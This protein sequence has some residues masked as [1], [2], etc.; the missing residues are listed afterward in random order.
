MPAATEGAAGSYQKAEVVPPAFIV[1]L[2]NADAGIDGAD[3]ERDR[4]DKAVPRS[5]QKASRLRSWPVV[6]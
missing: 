2:V 4:E 1:F 3:Q 6:L 5:T